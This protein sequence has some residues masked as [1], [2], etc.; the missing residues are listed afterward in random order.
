METSLIDAQMLVPNLAAGDLLRFL[1]LVLFIVCLP[2]WAISKLTGWRFSDRFGQL[3]LVNVLGVFWSS[4]SFWCLVGLGCPQWLPL[5]AALPIVAWCAMRMSRHEPCWR[6]NSRGRGWTAGYA[7]GAVLLAVISIYQP[8][9]VST[10]VA[11]DAEGLRL[12]GSLYSDKLVGAFPCASL[13]HGVPPR[14]L[15]FSGHSV[16]YH[17]LP[18]LFV[19]M[20]DS[21]VGVNF[22][23]GFWLYGMGYGSL[24]NGAAVLAFCRR[25]SR[26]Q[27]LAL[28]GLAM[29]AA[30]TGGPEAKTLNLA[31]ALLLLGMMS[32]ERARLSRRWRWAVLCA[33]LWGS[34]IGYEFYHAALMLAGLGVWWGVGSLWIVLSARFRVDRPLYERLRQRTMLAVPAVL[35]AAAITSVLFLGARRVAPPAFVW[36]NTYKRSYSREWRDWARTYTWCAPILEWKRGKPLSRAEAAGFVPPTMLQRGAAEVIYQAG[37]GVFVAVTYLGAG[38]F[39]VAYFWRRW[40]H[41]QGTNR[42]DALLLA[43]VLFGFVT[44]AV[45]TWGFETGETWLESPDVGRLPMY[46][47]FLLMLCGLGPLAQALRQSYRPLYWAPLALVLFA[48][49]HAARNELGLEPTTLYHHVSN[50]KLAALGC[51]RSEVGLDQAVLHPWNDEVIRDDSAGDEVAF[52]YK[53][54]FTL[55]SNLVGRQMYLEGRE[56]HLLS[57]GPADEIYRRSALRKGFYQHEPKA[58]QTLLNEREVDVVVADHEHPAPPEVSLHWERLLDRPGVQVYRR[59]ESRREG[60]IVLR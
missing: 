15:R 51:L 9:R 32:F 33:L 39:G 37:L 5:A 50:D 14:N 29:Y 21:T 20:T 31:M 57:S 52:L 4:W 41:Q 45:V 3:A 28:L 58:V 17:Y 40:R 46:G 36:E 26:S 10:L 59:P 35:V 2:G 44:P 27:R 54:H 23:D 55:G 30:F 13:Q 53:R 22:V 7:M 60:G 19:A 18:H 43:I 42:A 11:Y 24:I 38:V 1:A 6:R 47:M 49:G 25:H 12:Y 56:E 16:P 8:W 48:T 34:M